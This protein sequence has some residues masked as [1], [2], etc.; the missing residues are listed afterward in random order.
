MP[1]NC[2]ANS[3]PVF[4]SLPL[5]N[6]T[7]LVAD[8]VYTYTISTT[9][10][11]ADGHSDIKCVRVLFNYL[12]SNS[13]PSKA[14]GYLAWGVSDAEIVKYGGVWVYGDASGG[15][16]WAY[17]TDSWGG[18]TYITPVSCSTYAGGFASGGSGSRT[19]TWTFKVKPAWAQNPIV[20]DADYWAS[21]ATGSTGW[22][23][24]TNDFDVLAWACTTYSKTPTAPV[25][26]NATS[27]TITF[28]INPADSNTDLFCMKVYPT[29]DGKGYVQEDG[30]LGYTAT[31]RT[32][33]QWTGTI[34]RGLTSSTTYQF[35]ARSFTSVT[36]LCP[37]SLGVPA[38]LSTTVQEVNVD[39]SAQGKPISRL[40]YGNATRLD[41]TESVPAAAQKI[42][43]V[44]GGTSVRGVAGGLDADT[45]NWK[46]MS[47][48]G[49][50]HSGTPYDRTPTTLTWMQSVRDK[51]S[52]PMVTANLRGIGP[53][54]SS[55]YCRFYY[56]DTS[57]STLTSL[58]GDWVRY[59]NYILPTY[60]QGDTLSTADQAI[61]DSINWYGKPKLLAQGEASTP[62]VEYWELGNEPE[63]ALPWCT[64][65]ATPVALTPQEYSA[66][67]KQVANAMLAADPSIKLGPCLTT[68]NNGNAHL[69][70]VLADPA[71]RV[72]FIS[73][74]PYGPLYWYANNY[75]DTAETAEKALRTVKQQQVDYYNGIV[76][77]INANGRST[78]NIKLAASEWNV[79]DWRWEMSSQA[80]RMSHALGVAE[81]V[82]TYAEL[83]L[84]SANY[85]SMP[86]YGDGT[87]TPAFKLFKA[88]GQY[89]GVRLLSSLTD[90]NN[91]R[92]YSMWNS[93]T[94]ELCV[95]VLNFSNTADKL[96]K[97]GSI[98]VDDVDK[99]TLMQLKK[100]SGETTLLD[101][102]DP[103]VTSA[104][105]IDWVTSD[106]TGSV[107]PTNFTLTIP[108]STITLI[109]LHQSI[110]IPNIKS[111]ADGSFVS[112]S[113]AVVSAVYDGVF[114]IEADD[115]SSG[116]RVVMPGHGLIEGMR[117]SV[118][119]VV[120]TNGDGEREIA[121][122]SVN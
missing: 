122:V 33:A 68:A 15:Y 55:G 83:G 29:V 89:G 101:R 113:S 36:G 3:L 22:I 35:R 48:Q 114:Y 64:S 9:V 31:W 69:D 80:A 70:A 49:A 79:S 77:R 17:M 67:Y 20:N 119:G 1:C 43:E 87:E 116:V 96:V 90:G 50:G 4:T 30:S 85:W 93:S 66:H 45:Y 120:R 107:D 21:D 16:R 14:R 47:G 46:D 24:N 32:K 91:L 28:S 26:S 63:L 109:R 37:S 65:G 41:V 61:V 74:H 12:E 2:H 94:N 112:L 27:N 100:L 52:T 88:L 86:T 13:D 98:N 110:S 11:D 23:E 95:W 117:V 40:I 39:A 115:R 18:T 103:P 108:H 76:S 72:D 44:V 53:L 99:V 34:V 102:N 38:S 8:N 60:R 7:R 81:T 121:A 59:I 62:K 75:G 92:A 73:Y 54:A 58:A 5:T 84:F 82:F 105:A 57:I 71:N 111:I 56:S 6:A 10:T 25:L 106:L 78:N 97:F 118:S 51:A 104:P 42:W 19:V